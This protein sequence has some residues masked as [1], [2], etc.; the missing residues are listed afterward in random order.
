MTDGKQYL[1]PFDFLEEEQQVI[2]DLP[3]FEN[4]KN[5]NER[6][7]NLQF[8][9]RIN[10]DKQALT[11][12]YKIAFT[13]AM[14]YIPKICEKYRL[15]KK[16]IDREEKAHQAVTYIITSYLK[17]PHWALNKSWTGYLYQATRKFLIEKRKV[18]GIVDFVDL[19]TFF[20]EED[21]RLA[22]ELNNS[23]LN[24]SLNEDLAEIYE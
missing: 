13:I 10:G 20:K 18:D 21:N 4:P 24:G 9:Y 16:R 23:V 14:K 6:L 11:E 7:L 5:D 3:H 17:K 2:W 1:L 19:D 22:N 12:M 8:R 15:Q